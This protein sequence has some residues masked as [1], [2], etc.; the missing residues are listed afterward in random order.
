M[1]SAS[2]IQYI[3]DLYLASS[4]YLTFDSFPQTAAQNEYISHYVS[5]ASLVTVSGS[6]MWAPLGKQDVRHTATHVRERSMRALFI[7]TH[8]TERRRL[9]G[10][11]CSSLAA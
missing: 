4:C 11:N 9:G 10:C 8:P 6:H 2:D 7:Q 1:S 3:D 5:I